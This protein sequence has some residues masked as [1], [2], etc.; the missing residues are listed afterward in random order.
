VYLHPKDGVYRRTKPIIIKEE[1]K[2]VS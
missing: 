2:W 1:K